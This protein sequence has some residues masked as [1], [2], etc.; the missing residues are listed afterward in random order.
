MT[1]SKD[2]YRAGDTAEVLILSPVADAHAF[3]SLEGDRLYRQETMA[4]KGNVHR[5]RIPITEVMTPN[6][7]F[8]AALFH[9]GEAYKNELKIVAPPQ[10]KFLR[11]SVK[12][13]RATYPPGDV[14]RLE[15][16]T[17]DANNR[18]AAAD[19]SIGVADAALYALARDPAPAMRSFSYH[20]R[21]NNVLTNVSSAYRFSFLDIRRS[22]ACSSPSIGAGFRRLRR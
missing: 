13:D 16:N 5:Y 11:A 17:R 22:G 15:I 14:V 19:V 20:P 6:F 4:M 3:V 8:S 10:D 2:L 12:P 7:A 9:G 21:R 18:G 1:A